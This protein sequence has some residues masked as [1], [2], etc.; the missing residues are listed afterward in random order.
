MNK[1]QL[2]A[3]LAKKP[4]PVAEAAA[5][6]VAVDPKLAK[7]TL[8]DLRAMS[9]KV[10]IKLSYYN[11]LKGKSIAKPRARLI[12]D[13]TEYCNNVSQHNQSN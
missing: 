1:S 6:P 9:K 5:A 13:I 12:A 8:A 3:L 11:K 4:A 10:G 7:L 2:E